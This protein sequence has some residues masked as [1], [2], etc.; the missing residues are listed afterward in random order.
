[1]NCIPERTTVQKIIVVNKIFLVF[2]ALAFTLSATAQNT[3]IGATA[4]APNQSAML[5]VD[6]ITGLAQAKGILIPRITNAQRLA[7]NPLPAAAQ[8]LLV[9]QTNVAGAS[10]E[11][12]Y[13][14]SSITVV[15]NWVYLDGKGGWELAGNNNVTAANNFIGT[16]VNEDF[17]V[18]TNGAAATNERMRVLR[19]GEVIVN[20]TAVGTNT[21]DVFSVYASGTTNGT[22]NTSAIGNFAV[23]GY[24]ASTGIGVYGEN[25]G[26]GMGVLGYN[27]AL[28][29]NGVGVQGQS[30]SPNGYGIV[31]FSNLSLL[32]PGAGTAGYG[33]YGLASGVAPITGSAI[34]V[35][36]SSNLTI[37]SGPGIGVYGSSSSVSGFGVQAFNQNGVGTG[38]ITSGNSLAAN[39]LVAG[40][41]AAVTGNTVG[42]YTRATIANGGTGILAVS[43]G[44]GL[45]TLAGTGSAVSGSSTSFGV[46]G[47]AQGGAAGTARAGGYFDCNA[48]AS[49]AY[50]GCLTTLNVVRKIE[51]NGTVN[52]TVTDLAGKKVVLSAPEAPENFFQD[53]GEGELLNGMT[54]IVLDP[55]FSKNIV[56]NELHPLRVFV[57]L[58]G[59]C[60]GVYVTNENASGF[61]VKE[62]QNGNSNTK[63]YWTV[64][65]NRADEI[66]PDGSVSPY[67]AERFAPAIGAASRAT[68][69]SA[70]AEPLRDTIP[71]DQLPPV[72]NPVKKNMRATPSGS[73]SDDKQFEEILKIT[74]Y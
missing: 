27:A 57:Q 62:L 4:A 39:Y 5:D 7:M 44:A 28:A 43:N 24:S 47:W 42:T 71:G 65:A 55:I 70:A 52:T 37:T 46:V 12:F 9:Y 34:G 74:P 40:S 49:Y 15:P 19:T 25:T 16:L 67:S 38:L 35:R 69:Q 73:K 68:L 30:A 31:G 48:G 45:F 58:R 3:K 41:G 72:Q 33:V 11:G 61:D 32:N 8:G 21:G 13:Y 2:I 17:V 54:H 56:V 18:K 14:N 10:L 26:T 53:Y 20:N 36:G 51:G 64:T 66:L 59:D 60:K 22:T 1:M 6:G 50:V 29:G 63:F 23:N